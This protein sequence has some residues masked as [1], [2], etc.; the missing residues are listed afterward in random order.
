MMQ[1][2]ENAFLRPM[3]LPTLPPRTMRLAMTSVYSVIAVCT[4]VMVVP[5]S[6]ATVAMDTFITDVSSVMRNWPVASVKR[7]RPA[8]ALAAAAAPLDPD[9][10]DVVLSAISSPSRDSRQCAKQCYLTVSMAQCEQAPQV[11]FRRYSRVTSRIGI[12]R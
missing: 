2:K 7:M 10:P 6:L 3:M 8:P 9:A 5:R 12:A 1:P 11:A 4:P